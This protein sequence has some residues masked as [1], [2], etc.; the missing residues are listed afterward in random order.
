[1]TNPSVTACGLL[2]LTLLLALPA[3]G[4]QPVMTIAQAKAHLSRR[5][6]QNPVR[7]SGVVTFSDQSLGV[8]YVQDASG[9][10][11]FDPRIPSADALLPGVAVEVEGYLT[12][13]QGLTM[14]M[15]HRVKMGPP[16]VTLLPEKKPTPAPLQFDLDVAAQMR[17]DGL[18]TQVSGVIRSITVPSSEIEPMIVE[19]SSPSGHA[20][21][22]LPWREPQAVLDAWINEPVQLDAVLVCRA[23]AALLPE[24]AEALL[25]VSSRSHWRVQL[26]ALEEVFRRPPVLAASAIQPTPRSTLKERVHVTGTVTAAKERAWVCLRTDDGS[27]EVSTRQRDVFIPGQRLSIACWPQ[28]KTGRLMLQDGVCRVTGQDPPPRPVTMTQGFFNPSMQRELVEV[29]GT[30]HGHDL[31]GGSPQFTLALPSG[32]H[33]LLDWRSLLPAEKLP[34]LEDGSLIRL[35]GICH[36]TQ[37]SSTRSEGAVLSILPR[38]VE[39]MMIVS[40]PSW[41]TPGRLMLAVWWLLGLVSVALPGALIFRWQLWRQARRIRHIE[42]QAATEEERLRIAREFH[43]SLQ[44]QLTSAA[45]HME[46]LKGALHAAPE[47]LPRLID[48]TTAMLRH[49]QV[50]ARQ[51]IWDLRSDSTVRSSLTQTLDDWLKNRIPSEAHI[52]VNFTHEGNEPPLPEGAPF[53]LIRIVQEAVTNALAHSSAAHIRVRLY[54]SRRLVELVIEDD[55]SG[56]EPGL[57]SRPPPGHFGLSGLKERAAKIG[58]Q[59]DLS[60]RPGSGTRVTVRLSLSSPSHDTSH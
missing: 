48:D 51:C 34:S 21:A 17:I 46:T 8:A 49:C 58:A 59:L 16:E 41:W 30:L 45:L 1:M 18:L 52:Q 40:G 47:I 29:T 57:I 33:C 42:S 60:T 20:V 53:H 28:N 6:F 2:S 32:I 25:L 27:I 9:G 5:E 13:H 39:D 35:T 11:G 36:I 26:H 3:G 14:L 31:A 4:A 7:V 15:Q 50:E 10:I 23:D 37:D 19:I 55:G 38:S 44:Q 24:N 56:F 54:S 43:D 22:R 12:R